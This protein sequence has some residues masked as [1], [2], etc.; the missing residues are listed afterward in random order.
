MIRFEFPDNVHYIGGTIEKDSISLDIAGTKIP[1]KDTKDEQ[2]VYWNVNLSS[3]KIVE[4]KTDDTK[5]RGI[6]F[7]EPPSLTTILATHK[8]LIEPNNYFIWFADFRGKFEKS[9]NRTAPPPQDAKYGFPG[10]IAGI[11][12]NDPRTGKGYYAGNLGNPIRLQLQ[13]INENRQIWLVI[14]EVIL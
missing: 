5:G 13:V 4:T 14:R 1:G 7:G 12:T 10:F 9:D 6:V 2:K 3:P 8:M 11:G